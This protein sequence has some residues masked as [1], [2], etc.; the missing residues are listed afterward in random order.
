MEK[1][2]QMKKTQHWDSP[3]ENPSQNLIELLKQQTQN[4]NQER[5]TKTVHRRKPRAI[6]KQQIT[7]AKIKY[8]K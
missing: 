7:V 6:E 4:E 2:L 1:K 3:I 5:D 8:N